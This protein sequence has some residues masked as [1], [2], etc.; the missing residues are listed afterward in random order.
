MFGSKD[1]EDSQRWWNLMIYKMYATD[2]EIDEM[3]P[4]FGVIFLLAI[5]IGIV[6]YF[7]K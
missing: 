6:Y 2:K 1:D 5:I 7:C 4:V 3:M